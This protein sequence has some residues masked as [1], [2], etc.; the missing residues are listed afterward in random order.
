MGSMTF[1][2][3][4]L[5]AA[6]AAVLGASFWLWNTR[7][8]GA[9]P[10]VS[11]AK[12][13]TSLV[14][15][16]YQADNNMQYSATT[17]VT[18]MYG[19]DMMVSEAR[20]VRAPHKMAITYISGDKA[21][22]QS[23][24]N[25]RWFW[26]RGS[27]GNMVAYAEVPQRPSEM[28]ARRFKLMMENYRG[29]FLG[30]EELGGHAA[31]VV[32][33]RPIHSI[34]G[35]QG[36]VKRMWIDSKSGLTLRSDNYNCRKELVM[37]SVLSDINLQPQISQATFTPTENMRKA[38]DSNGWIA[39]EVGANASKVIEQTGISPPKAD[40]IPAG[41]ELDGHGVHTCPPERAEPV[42]AALTRYTDGLNTLTIFAMRVLDVTSE[43]STTG[44]K[45]QD[46]KAS[47]K[48]SCDFG[49]GTMVMRN[50]G[51]VRLLAVADLPPV[52]LERVL[53]AT[54]SEVVSRPAALKNP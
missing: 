13:A 10:A 53:D 44:G 14:N 20:V 47:E 17:K 30:D 21:G 50:K 40:W 24:Y 1:S 37:R 34:D 46:K 5:F 25:D 54:K 48:K 43:A 45:A 12:L 2:R 16:T 7:R 19:D 28:A 11:D 8:E 41:F 36:P 29:Y 51:S 42:L 39:L 9:T 52:T 32:E 3:Y 6:T 35:A 49:P 31:H 38:A 22:L 15:R 23:G 26:R 4:G 27:G 18:A 33:L